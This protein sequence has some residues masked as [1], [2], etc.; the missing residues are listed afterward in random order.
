MIMSSLNEYFEIRQNSWV[1]IFNS[2]DVDQC[3]NTFMNVYN[4]RVKQ[5]Y[6]FTID[7]NRKNQVSW[8]LY[9]LK[10]LIHKKKGFGVL[11]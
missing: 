11:S 8:Q 7:H 5:K 6:I 3:L 4:M 2:N 1:T 9:G 10:I